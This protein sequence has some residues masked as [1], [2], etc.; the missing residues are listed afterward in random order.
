MR[1]IVL[2]LL[3][4]LALGTAPVAMAEPTTIAP[5]EVPPGN[6]GVVFTN[7]P[8]IVDPHPM[9]V[10]SWSRHGARDVLA[11]HF[12]TGTPECYGV[13]ATVQETAESV[14]VELRGGTRADAVGRACIMIALSGTLE[15]PLQSPVGD[16]R[17]VSVY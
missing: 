12:T 6:P 14:T 9:P 13:N 15:V 10:E 11:L 16:R 5:P 3:V 17:V 8:S 7:D 1:A 2:G 4:G